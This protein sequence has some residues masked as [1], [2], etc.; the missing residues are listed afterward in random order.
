[1]GSRLG[2]VAAWAVVAWVATGT[3][4]TAA[5]Q[6]RVRPVP[7][8]GALTDQRGDR[9]FGVYIPTR[10]GGTL[11][12]SASDGAVD[13]LTG[14]DGRPQINGG[15]IGRDRHGWYTFR[16]REAEGPYR[17]SV[18]FVQVGEA[19]RMPWNFYYWPTK[20]DAILEP[21]AGG[22]GR[23]DTMYA[24][25]DDVLVATPGG[26]IAPG[27]DIVRP[28]LNGILETMPA[29][30]DTATWFPNLYDDLTWRGPEG[31][32]YQTPSPLLKYDQLFNSSAR[33]WEA[34]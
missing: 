15:E 19:D 10:Y 32:L 13:R 1:M 8:G 23:V 14:P 28:G 21:W 31:T 11:S 16:V 17:V 22:N 18:R 3:S 12:I 5:P 27:Q 24:N 4:A 20:G 30:G 9:Y 6:E 25:G 34:A 2:A 7:L 33:N 26:Y 29:A